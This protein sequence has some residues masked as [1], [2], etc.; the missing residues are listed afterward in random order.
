M[1]KLWFGLI[2]LI[3]LMASLLLTPP[4]RAAFYYPWCAVYGGEDG[5][6]TNCGF[7]TIEQ[8]R[9][10]ISGMGGFC[11]PNQFYTGPAAKPGR[12]AQTR[13]RD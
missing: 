6:G 9:A 2:G 8:C 12:R 5:G 3:A 11:A 13:N 7:S 10:T 1:R 4:A